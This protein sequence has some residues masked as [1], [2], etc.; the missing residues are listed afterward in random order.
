M[1]KGNSDF[2]FLRIE[3]E[4]QNCKAEKIFDKIYISVQCLICNVAS[5]ALLIFAVGVLIRA[6]FKGLFPS[7]ILTKLSNELKFE[8][9]E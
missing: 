1:K 9:S 6:E 3:Y 4:T 8:F 7:Q 2:V 5:N